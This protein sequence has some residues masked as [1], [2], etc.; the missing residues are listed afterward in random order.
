MKRLDD[1]LDGKIAIGRITNNHGL[2][3]NVKFFPYTNIRELVFSLDEILLYN[4]GNKKFFFSRVEEVKPLNRLYVFQLHGVEGINEAKKLKGFEVYIEKE[5]LPSLEKNEYYIFELIGSEVY[6]ED[7]EHA[8]K[9]TDV[10]QT[11]A[12]DVIQVTKNKKEEYLI[13]LIKEYI[14]EM[15][16][17]EKKF[18]VKRMEF[19]DD[20]TKD[21]D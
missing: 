5:D 13:P 14:I 19:L 18:I 21:E 9:I 7:G 17:E 15:N 3:G 2:Y 12:N 10:I 6:F 4:P 20:G 8:G 16:K 11:G 1:L